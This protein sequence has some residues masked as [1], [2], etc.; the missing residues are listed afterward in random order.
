M[1]GICTGISFALV[2]S[3]K[4]KVKGRYEKSFCFTH[5]NSNTRI[6]GILEEEE[7][8]KGIESQFKQPSDI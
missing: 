6:L 7:K 1:K 5:Q 4:S 8:E 2:W 3:M